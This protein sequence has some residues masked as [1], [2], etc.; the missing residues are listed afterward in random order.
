MRATEQP[1]AY[2]TEEA[3]PSHIAK[4]SKQYSGCLFTKWMDVLPQDLV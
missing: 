3:N 4:V 1:D 2:F